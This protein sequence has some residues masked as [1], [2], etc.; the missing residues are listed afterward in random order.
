MDHQE[1]RELLDCLPEDRT[2]FSYCRDRY[3]VDL[4]RIAS[5]RYRSIRELKRSGFAGLLGKPGIASLLSECGSGHIDSELLDN[6]WREPGNTFLLTAGLWDGR[7]G[8]HAQT[9][10][11]GINLVLRLN[12]NLQHDRLFCQTMQPS[13]PCAF[14]GCGHPVLKCGE[15]G[16]FRETLAWARLDIDLSTGEALVEEIQSDWVRAVGWLSWYVGDCSSDETELPGDCFS[17]TVG[18]ARAY[19]AYTGPLIRDWSQAMLAAVVDFVDRELGLSKIWYHTW[20]TG[21]L[22]KGIDRDWAPPTSL[23]SRLPKQF[24]FRETSEMPAL[25]SSKSVRKRFNRHKVA[26]RFFTL[27]L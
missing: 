12:F 14:N 16:Y 10:R 15:R 7:A 1:A 2:L 9:S 3:A 8:R 17:T 25:L 20:E 11:R 6:Y 27:E 5:R 26:P 4:L 19:L 21:V 22:L 18:Q 23:Y 13:Y 24:C